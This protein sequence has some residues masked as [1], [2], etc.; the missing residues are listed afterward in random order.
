MLRW[1]ENENGCL[2]T[3]ASSESGPLA[4]RSGDCTGQERETGSCSLLH[5]GIPG[6]HSSTL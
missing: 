1:G 6:G 5:L 3:L 4:T 2:L